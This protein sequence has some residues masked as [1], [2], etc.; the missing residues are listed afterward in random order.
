MITAANTRQASAGRFAPSPS[1][2]L[3]LGN[4]RTALLAYLAARSTG[5]EFLL[6]ID[7]LDR[8][9]DAG[10]GEQQAADLAALGITWDRE[11]VWQH[12]A[13]VRYQAALDR[14]SARGYTYECVC[15]R[16]DILT[17]PTAPHS[18]PG[19]YP[20]TCSKLTAPQLQD[21][22]AQMFPR[23][24][25]IRL[26]VPEHLREVTFYDRVLG[27][28]PGVVDDFV[29]Q[30]GDGTHSYNLATV[31]DDAHTG[32]DQIV[33]GDDLAASTPRQILLARLLD[34]PVPDYAHV[35]LAL[36]AAG[37]RLAKRDGAVTLA[38]LAERG[39]TP[40]QVLQQLAVSAQ[41]ASAGE[42]VTLPQLVARFSFDKIARTP[43]VYK[44]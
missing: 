6:R 5:R 43:W 36:N 40:G 10:Y 34:L 2:Q 41:L 33:R 44:D 37:K 31:V 16:K 38:Q 11:I 18:A 9:R 27:E 24:P 17:A 22:K 20:G 39:V 15:T 14:L 26:R 25:A 19:A 21:A 42:Q 1:G 7:S 8:D 28:V 35:P 29:L 23:L 13:T 12:S 4:L 3:H 30:R 32:V